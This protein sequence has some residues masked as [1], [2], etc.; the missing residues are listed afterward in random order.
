MTTSS[1]PPGKLDTPPS[2]AVVNGPAGEDLDWRAIDWRAVEDSVRRLRQRIFTASQAGDL[3]R[4][5]NPQKLLL[6][7]RANALLSVRRV[8]QRNDPALLPA[9]EPSGLA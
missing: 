7:S 5:R 6:R 4:V 2:A 3:K 9:R 8:T 1:E